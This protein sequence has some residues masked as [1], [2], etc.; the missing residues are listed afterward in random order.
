MKC[1]YEFGRR[2]SDKLPRGSI[3]WKINKLHVSTTDEEI[4]NLI[5]QACERNQNFTAALTKQAVA[6]AMACHRSNQDLFMFVA[7][8]R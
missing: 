3:R 6:Y 5:K 8:G 1:V 4:E 7:R 2:W